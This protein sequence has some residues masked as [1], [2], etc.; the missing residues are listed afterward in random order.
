MN[1][2]ARAVL[3]PEVFDCIKLQLTISAQLLAF[4]AVLGNSFARKL[5]LPAFLEENT[6]GLAIYS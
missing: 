4:S 6:L 3:R 2:Q 5:Q 1:G